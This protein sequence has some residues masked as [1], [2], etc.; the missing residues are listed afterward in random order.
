MILSALKAGYSRV[1]Q[2]LSRSTS[3]LGLA[4]SSLFG[5]GG[6]IDA[7]ALDKLE[8]LFYEADFGVALAAELT[9]KV[10]LTLQ[11]QPN[12]KPEDV[13]NIIHADLVKELSVCSPL[14]NW[15]AEGPTVV[16]I[17]GVNGN[18]KTTS[19]AKLAKHWHDAGKKVLLAAAD[20]YRAAAVEQLDLWAGQLDIDIV[21]GATRSDPS[22]VTFDALSAAKARSCDVVLVDTAGRLHTK[23][24][25]MQ[26]LEKLRRTCTKVIPSAPHETLL[27]LDANNGQNGIDQ[28]LAF[29]RYIPLTGLVITKLDGRAKGG[30]VLQIQRQLGIPVKFIGIGEGADD[31]QPFDAASYCSALLA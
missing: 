21:K 25:L 7:A 15:A 18:G 30:I 14:I 29:H 31:L 13:L 4:I 5:R 23:T 1:V 24:P 19:T 12:L 2:A 6:T 28:A 9:E 8:Q 20:T 22:A 17:V 16:A 10:R 27:V 26:E 3:Q 11:Q